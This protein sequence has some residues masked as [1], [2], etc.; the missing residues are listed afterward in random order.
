MAT[1]ND[2]PGVCDA[3]IHEEERTI[4]RC[5][6]SQEN[7][8]RRLASRGLICAGIPSIPEGEWNETLA[9]VT[10]KNDW[11]VLAKPGEH[12]LEA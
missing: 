10:K 1:K 8:V 2:E 12:C 7:T 5:W 11:T 4:R 3:G 6:P 9:G